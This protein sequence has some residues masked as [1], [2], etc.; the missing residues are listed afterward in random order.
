M[1]AILP[2]FFSPKGPLVKST[3]ACQV[4][5]QVLFGFQKYLESWLLNFKLVQV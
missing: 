5:W 3:Y 2:H 4:G 1:E